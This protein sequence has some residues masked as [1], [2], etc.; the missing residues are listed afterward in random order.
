MYCLLYFFGGSINF[1]EL[2]YIDMAAGKMLLNYLCNPKSSADR[3]LCFG[4]LIPLLTWQCVYV[5]EP[6]AVALQFIDL[7]D[8]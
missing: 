4:I 6:I 7:S 5:G 3:I 2:F 8:I 1:L